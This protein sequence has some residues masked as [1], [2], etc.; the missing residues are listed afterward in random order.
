MFDLGIFYYNKN[1]KLLEKI[2][3]Q[4]QKISF[5]D[6]EKYLTI[7]LVHIHSYVYFSSGEDQGVYYSHLDGVDAIDSFNLFIDF[8]ITLTTRLFREIGLKQNDILKNMHILLFV[9]AFCFQE[10][11]SRQLAISLARGIVISGVPWYQAIPEFSKLDF[12]NQ[13]IRGGQFDL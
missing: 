1:I 9:N 12:N 2:T 10:Y 11:Y 7:Y 8:P 4:N 3:Q 13:P 6:L 5:R